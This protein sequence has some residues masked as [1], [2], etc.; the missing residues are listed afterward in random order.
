MTLLPHNNEIQILAI[1]M[2][3]KEN[4]CINYLEQYAIFH[5]WSHN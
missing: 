4:L 2:Q 5:L 1:S 3:V